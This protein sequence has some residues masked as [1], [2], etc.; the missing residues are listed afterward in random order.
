MMA[1][2][3]E[4]RRHKASP[5]QRQAAFALGERVCEAERWERKVEEGRERQGKGKES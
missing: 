5:Q 1:P 2:S 3:G 4:K